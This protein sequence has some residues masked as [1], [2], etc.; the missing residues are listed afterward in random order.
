MEN[1]RSKA[2]TAPFEPAKTSKKNVCALL[3]AGTAPLGENGELDSFHVVVQLLP[4]APCRDYYL[5]YNGSTVGKTFP[6]F[7]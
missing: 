6:K 3:F 1:N 7:R 4:V 5:L 2:G